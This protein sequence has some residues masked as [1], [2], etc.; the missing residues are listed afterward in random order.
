MELFIVPLI[1]ICL[2]LIACWFWKKR[3]R[4]LEAQLYCFDRFYHSA[5]ALATDDRTPAHVLQ[6]IAFISGKL[7][8]QTISWTVIF[9]LL[10]G[11][12]KRINQ[13]A[14]TREITNEIANEINELPSELR[15]HLSVALI[16]GIFA[17]THNNFIIGIF[18]R[19]F[20]MFGVEVANRSQ[21]QEESH[22]AEQLV[23][24]MY[25]NNLCGAV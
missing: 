1:I 6:L 8:S 7:H 10:R 9:L 5:D 12:I 25:T 15:K 4:Q 20:T 18:L 16:A 23:E 3:N 24:G 13:N 21:D 11:D 19:R 2:S 22:R 14:K 17:V